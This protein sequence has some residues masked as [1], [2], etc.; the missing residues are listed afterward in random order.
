L[1]EA[2][3]SAYRNTVVGERYISISPIETYR[4]TASAENYICSVRTDAYR[5]L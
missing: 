1:P 5:L 2:P 4:R 3:G